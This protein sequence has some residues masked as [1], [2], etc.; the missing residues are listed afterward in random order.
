M[1]VIVILYDYRGKL[2]FYFFKK[3][4]IDIR[5]KKDIDLKQK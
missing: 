1:L 2:L 3:E 5:G 4:Y